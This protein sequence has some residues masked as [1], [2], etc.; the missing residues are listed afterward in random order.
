[1]IVLYNAQDKTYTDGGINITKFCK[2]ARV[3][4]MLNGSFNLEVLLTYNA[5]L[6][7]SISKEMQ[8][9]VPTHRNKILTFRI[10]DITKDSKTLKLTCRHIFWD[11][12]NNLIEDIYIKTMGGAD[13]I[14][15]ILSNGQ[16]ETKWTGDSDIDVAKNCRIVREYQLDALMG[17]DDN[18][19]KS[20]WGGELTIDDYFIRI[21]KRR[22]STEPLT[23]SFKKDVLGF[24]FYEDTS[25]L[26]TRIM[27][28]GFDGILLP[29][30]Y[31]DSPLIDNYAM[32]Y[33]RKYKM[34]DIKI[35]TS[36]SEGDQD[37]GYAS[38]D[39]AYKEMR[40]RVTEELYAEQEVDKPKQN[41]R[42]NLRT[43]RESDQY[44]K[45][46]FDK[47]EGIQLGDSVDVDISEYNITTSK[48]CI[49][50][51]YDCLLERY[52][53]VELGEFKGYDEQDADYTTPEID[54][55]SKLEPYKSGMFFHR[56]DKALTLSTAK[57]QVAFLTFGTVQDSHLQFTMCVVGNATETG[58]A[59]M[60]LELDNQL[61]EIKP[62]QTVQ[63]GYFTWTVTIPLLF[64][65]GNVSHSLAVSFESTT[66]I[67]VSK[68]QLALTIYGQSISGGAGAS[69]PHA[70]ET[71]EVPNSIRSNYAGL[72][73]DV[74]AVEVLENFVKCYDNNEVIPPTIV[75]TNKLITDEV[76][77]G[78][79]HLG[80]Q[81]VWSW[82][83]YETQ[84][85]RYTMDSTGVKY[86][87][88]TVYHTAKEVQL[89]E[90]EQGYIVV[91]CDLPSTDV[92]YIIGEGELV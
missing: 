15:Y 85:T 65:T 47:L 18:T 26:A 53:E 54:I 22:G 43:L 78:V 67:A 50:I 1:M 23:I 37:E 74:S 57:Q 25:Q 61:M 46:G 56:N 52:V 55:D 30:L 84:S 38:P 75:T 77:V 42:A 83:N 21:D 11:L 4:E 72:L 90:G 62:M 12:G 76:D 66:N 28:I 34:E 81:S 9:R 13:A 31:V 2:S 39:E 79:T 48:R 32:P 44:R 35:I 16:Y 20:R 59:T 70:E 27:P 88:D 60:Y 91:E 19:F 64:I 6:W 89:V 8:I 10:K 58:V 92:Y 40:R 41:I 73:S 29:E 71:E 68:E 51:E 63:P 33:I 3:K 5:I 7:N 69:Y 49:S 80:F 14:N 24:E 45:Y 17:S 36:D 87:N 86:N 82:T